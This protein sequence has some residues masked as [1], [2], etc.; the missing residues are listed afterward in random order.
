MSNQHCPALVTFHAFL[1]GRDY[2]EVK[3]MF[4]TMVSRMASCELLRDYLADLICASITLKTSTLA[5][6][7]LFF[8][9]QNLPL[10]ELGVLQLAG[11]L[12]T[13]VADADPW[14]S[15]Y[16]HALVDDDTLMELYKRHLATIVENVN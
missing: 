2:G 13:Y 6:A 16:D 4:D 7:S 11:A 10:Y 14:S 8:N 12:A 3:T 15:V 9:S 1:D 5:N